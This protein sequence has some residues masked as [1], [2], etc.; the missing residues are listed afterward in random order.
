LEEESD[1]EVVEGIKLES[2]N[3][4]DWRDYGLVMLMIIKKHGIKYG[5]ENIQKN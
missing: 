3:I 1:W 2:I 4:S 5:N